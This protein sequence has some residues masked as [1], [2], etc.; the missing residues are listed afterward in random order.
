MAV[1]VA[2]VARLV[3]GRLVQMELTKRN[4]KMTPAWDGSP[5]IPEAD[6]TKILASIR[7]QQEESHRRNQARIAA[8]RWEQRRWTAL[9]SAIS[10]CPGEH[11]PA[12]HR[13][14]LRPYILS[15]MR[16]EPGW[17]EL[18]AGPWPGQQKLFALLKTN[19][20]AAAAKFEAAYPKPEV[21]K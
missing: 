16:G 9:L 11:D 18:E 6:A 1:P 21:P 10:H 2:D 3:D 12:M 20:D 15:S 8:A 5:T 4:V 13:A 7:A 17:R 14:V 19:V